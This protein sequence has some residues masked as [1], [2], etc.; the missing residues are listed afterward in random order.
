MAGFKICVVG[1]VFSKSAIL[2]SI[3]TTAVLSWTPAKDNLLSLLKAKGFLGRLLIYF[4][5]SSSDKILPS[6]S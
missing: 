1:V 2:S 4:S 3:K 5:N 6:I